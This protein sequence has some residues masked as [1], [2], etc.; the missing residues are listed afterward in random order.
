MFRPGT[1]DDSAAV[2]NIFLES[3]TDLTQRLG[4]APATPSPDPEAQVRAWENRRPLY[5]HLAHHA[6]QFWVAEA[7][8]QLIGYARSTLRGRVRQLTEFFVLPGQQSAGVG[9]ELLQRAFPADS[10]RRLIIATLDTR[11]QVRYMK[12]GIYPQ[13]PATVFSRPPQAVDIDSDLVFQPV[14][15]APEH[16]AAL[17]GID[18]TIIDYRREVD[19]RWLMAQRQGFLYLRDGQ[20]VGYGYVGHNSGPFALLN[21]SDYPAVLAHAETQAAAQNLDTFSLVLPLINRAAVD[22]LL[23]RGFQLGGFYMFLMANAPFGRLE[24]YIINSPPFFL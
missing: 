21:D 10:E 14:S 9:R 18:D 20:A 24:N 13:F 11:A 2:F 22:Y 23:K 7:Q 3:V 12:A 15:T 4:L 6:D 8:G 5:A 17:N 19:H 1:V 16:L